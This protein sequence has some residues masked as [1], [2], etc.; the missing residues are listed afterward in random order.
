M[1][2]SNEFF[3]WTRNISKQLAESNFIDKIL[4][5]N[6]EDIREK[7]VS[8]RTNEDFR[9]YEFAK[10]FIDPL[11]EFVFPNSCFTD[12]WLYCLLYSPS[13]ENLKVID[14][15]GNQI[16][17]L[18]LLKINYFDIEAPELEE[19]Y[20]DTVVSEGGSY[21]ISFFFETFYQ[22]FVNLSFLWIEAK[23]ENLR[24]ENEQLKVAQDDG[25]ISSS[26]NHSRSSSFAKKNKKRIMKYKFRKL[27]LGGIDFVDKFGQDILLGLSKWE[28]LTLKKCKFEVLDEQN[29]F[30]NLNS[31]KSLSIIKSESVF[32][33][34]HKSDNM[35]KSLQT[36]K[37][38]A[39]KNTN[40]MDVI[41]MFK[42]LKHLRIANYD[43][44]NKVD[45]NTKML[46]QFLK[47]FEMIRC[48]IPIQVMQD[49]CMHNFWS[50]SELVLLGNKFSEAPL[51]SQK[52]NSSNNTVIQLKINLSLFYLVLY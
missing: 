45:F 30:M 12:H 33:A 21:N 20:L 8:D 38:N 23:Q 10:D 17:S 37:L 5:I 36:L 50:V 27:F 43:F 34:L 11:E 44:K 39:V 19:L 16:K 46:P 29:P 26:S 41:K 48:N 47:K 9:A 22:K 15:R 32:N 18:L 6:Q 13:F 31:L 28:E 52:V 14:L 1:K 24:I 7:N 25:N 35:F 49:I 2:L 51:N 4:R 42:Y 40:I 3:D